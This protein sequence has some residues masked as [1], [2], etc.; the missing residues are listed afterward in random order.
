MTIFEFEDYKAFVQKRVRSMPKGGRGEFQKIAEALHVHT[1]QISK[2]F[3]G[4]ADLTL[5][6]AYA[7]CIYLGLSG[8]ETEYFVTLVNIERAGTIE[9][10]KFLK[11][12]LSH[13]KEQLPQ[14][15]NRLPTDR[16]LSDSDRATFYSAWFYTAVSLLCSVP[17]FQ[18]VD[19]IA[20]RLELQKSTVSKV[21][22]F[23]TSTGI[24]VEED[25]RIKPATQRTHIGADSILVTRHHTNWRLK[26]IEN[27]DH[28]STT[29]ELAFTSPLMVSTKDIP[30]IREILGETVE[31]VMKLVRQSGA[32][33]LCCLNVD[34]FEL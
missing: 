26:A 20:S 1:T 32:E 22:E 14:L 19:S 9:F 27:F 8:L 33:S 30:R 16:I 34:W 5:E 13:L 6:Q 3:S 31:K 23:L 11:Q 7:L 17:E 24:C 25:G 12:K 15:V 18:T 2:V 4:A 29:D 10:K 21:F 28:L